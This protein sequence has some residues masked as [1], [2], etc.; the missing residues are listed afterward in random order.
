MTFLTKNLKD[1]EVGSRIGLQKFSRK[2][3]FLD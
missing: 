3:N 1:R 2:M